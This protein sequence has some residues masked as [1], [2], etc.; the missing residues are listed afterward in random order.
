MFKKFY[1][2]LVFLSL[3]VSVIFSFSNS[4]YDYYYPITNN[5]TISSSYG[6][7][8]LFGKYNFHDGIDIPSMV[9]TPVY[10]IQNGVIKYIGF[11]DN[12]Y[13][14]YIIILHSNSYK[15]IYGHLSEE[16]LVNIGD[17]INAKQIIAYVGPKILSNGMSNGN[18][19]G[20]HLHFSIYSNYGKSIDP[21]T[22]EYQK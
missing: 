13:G 11:D 17:T 16:Q 7:R 1:I 3:L 5:Y 14:N 2:Y 18:T 12:G 8:E 22:L 6:V 19:T 10:S 20:P 9:D 21:L 4:S 15:S